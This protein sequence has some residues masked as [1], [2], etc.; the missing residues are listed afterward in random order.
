[1]LKEDLLTA[2]TEASAAKKIT[3][4]DVLVAFQ[5]GVGEVHQPIRNKLSIVTILYAIGGIIAC[6]G[7]ILF[8]HQQWAG[9]PSFAR[10]LVTLGSGIAAYIIG[11]LFTQKNDVRGA[12]FA[13]FLLFCLL[14]PFGIFITLKETHVTE[15]MVGYSDIIYGVMTVWTLASLFLFKRMVFRVFCIIFGSLLFFSITHLLLKGTVWNTSDMLEYRFLL[16]GM[17][18]MLL[19]RGWQRTAIGSIT[20]WLYSFG[21]IMLLG[22]T[23]ALGG[24]APSANQIWE[25]LFVGIVFGMTFLS[26]AL[27]SRATLIISSI[28][29]MIYI[30]KITAEYFS[31]TIGWPLSLIGAGF[32]L[33]AVGYGTLTVSKRYITKVPAPLAE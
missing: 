9:M 31:D 24:Y 10:I 22:S 20:P 7:I 23:M 32:L 11:V 26:I 8:F 3:Q 30:L 25:I 13:F 27:K 15:D 18:Y 1:M 2:I 14:T 16:L 19:G 21:S 12:A 4:Q 29:I 17:S 6:I 33:I 28:S 5:R